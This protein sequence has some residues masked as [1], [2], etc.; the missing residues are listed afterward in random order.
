MPGALLATLLLMLE[1]E[2]TFWAGVGS[3]E[4]TEIKAGITSW[5]RNP[6]VWLIPREAN[7]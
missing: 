2:Q 3:A 4:L 7:L 6:P 5:D 1:P